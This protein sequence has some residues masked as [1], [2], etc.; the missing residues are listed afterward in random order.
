ME[1][2]FYQ[3]VTPKIDEETF[4]PPYKGTGNIESY[5]LSAPSP[6]LPPCYPLA[7]PLL[8]AYFNIV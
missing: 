4:R 6:L 8:S 1:N 3:H 5:C 2:E 7:S